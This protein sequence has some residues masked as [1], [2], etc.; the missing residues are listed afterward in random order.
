MC[1]TGDGMIV[2]FGMRERERGR[3]LEIGTWQRGVSVV[4]AAW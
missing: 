2:L 4:A 1:R 3:E